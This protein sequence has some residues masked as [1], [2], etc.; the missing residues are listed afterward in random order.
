MSENNETDFSERLTAIEIKLSY[1]ENF[2]KELQQVSVEHT[3]KIERLEKENK[4]LI[5]KV[6]ELS[7]NA[8]G[9]IPNRRPPHY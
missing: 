8:E 1:M 7:D 4:L 2:C 6:K 5:N 9:D 3:N